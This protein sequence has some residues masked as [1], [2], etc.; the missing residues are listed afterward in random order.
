MTRSAAEQIQAAA[1][2]WHANRPLT[3]EAMT[4][5]VARAFELIALQPRIGVA[6][7]SAKLAGVR[8]VRLA[9]VRYYL[10]YRVQDSHEAVDVLAFWHASRGT[11]PE[12]R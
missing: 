1:A 5:E 3:P 4:Q 6:A 2:W 7:A 12:L 11:D 9:R 8:R 10:Y